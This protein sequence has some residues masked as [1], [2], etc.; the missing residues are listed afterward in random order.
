MRT[1]QILFLL[2]AGLLLISGCASSGSSELTR[3]QLLAERAMARAYDGA[4]P[5]IPHQVAALGRTNCSGCHEPGAASNSSRIAPP[6]SHGDWGSCQQCHV[7]QFVSETFV[8]SHLEPFRDEPEGTQQTAI[9][10]PMIPHSTQ[11]REQ[12]A[13]CHMGEQ[14]PAALRAPHEMRPNCQQ[15]HLEAPR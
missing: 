8:A 3:E 12:C 9:A 13:I 14:A 6:R 15:C 2:C 10:P 7:E 1:P 11:G 5:V 4:P